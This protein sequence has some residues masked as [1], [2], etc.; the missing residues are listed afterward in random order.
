[1]PS[2][3]GC[4]ASFLRE[5]FGASLRASRRVREVY[6]SAGDKVKERAASPP[7]FL[8]TLDVSRPLSS[9]IP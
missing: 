7:L 2:L 1:M 6:S 5:N 9:G 8:A 3:T 4:I